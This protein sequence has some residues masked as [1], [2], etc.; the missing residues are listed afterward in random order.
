MEILGSECSSNT[1]E[2]A[3]PAAADPSLASAIA[4]MQQRA[5][6]VA[7]VA[8]YYPY[9]AAAAVNMTGASPVPQQQ[10]VIPS[11]ARILNK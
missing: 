10:A 8:P 6:A 9:T 7:A 2:A 3:S 5:A 4:V 1:G 11:Q